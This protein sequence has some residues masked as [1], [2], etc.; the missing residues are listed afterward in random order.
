MGRVARGFVVDMQ[1]VTYCAAANVVLS[2]LPAGCQGGV[3]SA[4][5]QLPFQRRHGGWLWLRARTGQV[6]E[7]S[8]R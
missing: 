5:A 2:P 3:D 6:C 4:V 8:G 1:A 7:Q